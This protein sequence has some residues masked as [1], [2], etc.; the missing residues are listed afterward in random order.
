METWTTAKIQKAS[1]GRGRGKKANGHGIKKLRELILDLAVR[2]KL[3]PQHPDDEPASVLLEKIDAE[4]CKMNR[5]DHIPKLT[6][7]KS[8]FDPTNDHFS[9][10][11][12]WVWCELQ[13]IASFSN[14]KAHEQFVA[15]DA[16]FI[17]INSR[18]VSTGG[19]IVKHVAERLSPLSIGDMAIVMSDVPNG[20]A[21]VRCY[22]VEQDN[23][24]TLNQRIGC[25]SPTSNLSPE[26]LYIVLD[27]NR[28]FLRYDD[29]QKQ[30]NLKKIQILSCP[31]PLP[32]LQE[33]LRIVVKVDELMALCDHLEQEQV[34][35]SETH[36]LLVK[37][38]LD[39]LT[40]STD[41]KD[42]AD[43][44][45]RIEENFDILFTTPESI[46][47]LKQTILQLGIE[48]KLTRRNGKDS[49]V[50]ASL[51]STEVANRSSMKLGRGV[52]VNLDK[53][54]ELKDQPYPLPTNWTYIRLGKIITISGGSQ[55]PKG[56][57]AF[58]KK[59]GYTRLIQI[60][61]F[62][63]DAF[64]TYI[65]DEYANRPFSEDDIMIGRYGPP[66]FQILRGK[67]GTYNVAL[68]KA[69]P[70][71]DFVSRDY[72]Y[73]LL[74]EPRIQSLVIGESERTAGQSG[75]RKEL[76]YMFVIGLPPIEEQN[77]IVTIVEET[78]KLCE[79][80]KDDLN[81]AI[82]TQVLLADGLCQMQ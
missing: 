67:K 48:G 62:K 45:Q 60:R 16:R 22:I 44:W 6:R 29:G 71:G 46:D 32:P 13:D 42:F 51:N 10:P 4:L 1:G 3:V 70:V 38:L 65:P 58:E 47:E 55:P 34:N 80:L 68:M 7:D 61:D 81:D 24:Y 21:L 26:Y 59:P 56:V 17:L 15:Q 30:T 57:F 36:Q 49:L 43:S 76:L 35:N 69:D 9:L 75:V 41:H 28:Y 77:R 74:S 12:Q 82:T 50:I 2:G 63:S 78:F 39:T 23:R 40:S 53:V 11:A 33:Q 37:T 54:I 14:G 73:Y 31:I 18:F 20:R 5:V 79:S 66:V 25:I 8:T 72:L 27:R 52:T 19:R 64:P